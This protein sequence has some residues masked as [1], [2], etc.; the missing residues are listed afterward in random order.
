MLLAALN[1]Y[2]NSRKNNYLEIRDGGN[3]LGTRNRIVA[4]RGITLSEAVGMTG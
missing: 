1:G 3:I 2:R 4:S